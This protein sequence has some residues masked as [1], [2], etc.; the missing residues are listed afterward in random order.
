VIVRNAREFMDDVEIHFTVRTND[1]G[2]LK[3]FTVSD[4]GQGEYVFEIYCITE[5]KV[6]DAPP[7]IIIHAD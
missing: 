1:T 7:R 3:Y 6:P 4:I 2:A 5:N